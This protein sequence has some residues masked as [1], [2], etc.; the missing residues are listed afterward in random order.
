MSPPLCFHGSDLICT[1]L[2]TSCLRALAYARSEMLPR[3]L[4]ILQVSASHL[5]CGYPTTTPLLP[6]PGGIL[7]CLTFQLLYVLYLSALSVAPG[8]CVSGTKAP[9]VQRSCLFCFLAEGRSSWSLSLVPAQGQR[10]SMGC[11]SSR[12]ETVG[13]QVMTLW[14]VW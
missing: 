11:V 13:M 5:T 4:H 7:T 1:H 12:G 9:G 3:C 10:Q 2:H 8:G 6:D 14:G